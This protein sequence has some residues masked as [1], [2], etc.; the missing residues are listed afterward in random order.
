MVKCRAKQDG[1]INKDKYVYEGEIFEAEKCPSWAE[2]VEEPK[3]PA[4]DK[5][6][7]E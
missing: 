7:E 3:K 2:K 1:L 6:A 5:K 4:K